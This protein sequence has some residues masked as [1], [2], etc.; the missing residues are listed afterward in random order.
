M[1]THVT[2]PDLH[3][4]HMLPPPLVPTCPLLQGPHTS[5][6]TFP[7]SSAHL[8]SQV[9]QLILIACLMHMCTRTRSSLTLSVLLE[10]NGQSAGSYTLPITSTQLQLQEAEADHTTRQ[11]TS[12]MAWP[13]LCGCNIHAKALTLN[14]S[15]RSGSWLWSLVQQCCQQASIPGL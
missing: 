3:S 5:P 9:S 10:Y 13:L 2:Q 14:S 1:P 8:L 11:G 7:V 15:T 12:I 4:A 6:I